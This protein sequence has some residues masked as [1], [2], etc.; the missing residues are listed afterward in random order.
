MGAGLNRHAG[1]LQCD[2]AVLFHKA[3]DSD[4]QGG[5]DP[6]NAVTF[7]DF[8]GQAP[9][10]SCATVPDLFQHIVVQGVYRDLRHFVLGAE[11]YVLEPR[12]AIGQVA[13][14]CDFEKFWRLQLGNGS[15]SL[16]Y[17]LRK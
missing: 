4:V 7:I 8:V 9:S 15:L 6:A 3:G 16:N 5:A 14:Q 12:G 13:D 17:N 11:R 1:L 10:R 2:T